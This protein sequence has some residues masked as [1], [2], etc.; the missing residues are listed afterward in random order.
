[1]L[2]YMRS[3]GSR[4][5]QPFAR[6]A[7][8]DHSSAF[9]AFHAHCTHPWPFSYVIVCASQYWRKNVLKA[10]LNDDALPVRPLH[11]PT[12][13]EPESE[14]S[15]RAPRPRPLRYRAQSVCAGVHSPTIVQRSNDESDEA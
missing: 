6:P 1:M 7:W 11:E 4:G 13:V 8:Y 2:G 14:P 5:I 3:V 9:S 12:R 10:A 15:Y